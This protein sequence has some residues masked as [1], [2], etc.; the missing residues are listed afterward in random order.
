MSRLNFQ[1]P[2]ATRCAIRSPNGTCVRPPGTH[3]PP[4]EGMMYAVHRGAGVQL[5]WPGHHPLDQPRGVGV[6]GPHPRTEQRHRAS[7]CGVQHAS[8]VRTLGPTRRGDGRRHHGLEQG[9][10]PLIRPQRCDPGCCADVGITEKF[11]DVNQDNRVKKLPGTGPPCSPRAAR[12]STA[13]QP[14]SMRSPTTCSATPARWQ[15]EGVHLRDSSS[16]RR[17]LLQSAT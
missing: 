1:P 9:C 10:R 12:S 5:R 6:L 14:T 2:P 3:Q 15:P 16:G 11:T 13:A 8:H 17:S 4:R 7:A